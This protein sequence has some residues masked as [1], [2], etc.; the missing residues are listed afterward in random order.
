MYLIGTDIGYGEKVP[1]ARMVTIMNIK[2]RN[3]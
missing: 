2:I 3:Y 1:G